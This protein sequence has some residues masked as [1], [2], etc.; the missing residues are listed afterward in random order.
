MRTGTIALMLVLS[1]SA[2]A[3]EQPASKSNGE[4]S[5]G[6]SVAEAARAVGHATRDVAKEVGHATRDATKAVGHAS[7]D[8]AKDAGRAVAAG[9]KDVKQAV[10]SD[11]SKDNKQDRKPAANP[12]GKQP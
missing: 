11:K 6:K 8:V 3:A 1:I 4:D 12:A 2:Y 7:R 10:T 9:A 5:A